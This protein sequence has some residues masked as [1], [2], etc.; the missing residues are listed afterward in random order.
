MSFDRAANSEV[1]RTMQIS[2]LGIIDV[3]GEECQTPNG[4]FLENYID[5]NRCKIDNYHSI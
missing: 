1:L 2:V 5:C 3:F 4:N